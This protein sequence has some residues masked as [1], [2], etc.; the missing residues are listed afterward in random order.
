MEISNC[1][2]LVYWAV[3]SLQ[4]KNLDTNY[5]DSFKHYDQFFTLSLFPATTIPLETI[6]DFRAMKVTNIDIHSTHLFSTT[7]YTK[8]NS[9]IL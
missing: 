5:H 8:K 4:L 9:E 7:R 1:M 3:V 6:V 2:Y